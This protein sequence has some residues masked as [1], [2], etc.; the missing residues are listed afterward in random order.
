MKIGID[1][2]V[3]GKKRTGDETYTRELVKNLLKIDNTNQYFLFTNTDSSAEIAEIE[4]ILGL[5]NHKNAC[6][7]PVLPASKV[8]WTFF[9]LPRAL[10]MHPVDILHVQ[11]ITPLWLP[12][13]IKLVTTVHD[14]SFNVFSQYIDKKDLFFLKTLLPWSLKRADAVIGVSQFTKGEILKYYNL[15]EEKV[16]AVLNGGA[17]EGF[18]QPGSSDDARAVAE[19]YQLPSR[20]VLYVG[21]LQPR[22]RIP[23]LV[24]N[25][26]HCISRHK[27]L[28]DVHLV[29]GGN[30]SA[31]NYD[32]EIDIVLE[33][34]REV[35][36]DLFHRVHFPGFFEQEH[37]PEIYRKAE[38]F[39]STSVYE[40]FNLP[41][42]EAMAVGTPVFCEDN[43]C[44]REVTSG[45]ASM[46]AE[47]DSADFVQKLY[48]IL[49]DASLRDSLSEKGRGQAARFSWSVTA[50][51]T[52]AL[53][54][55]L[56]KEN[57]YK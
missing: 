43:A 26:I 45:N 27:E 34:I 55:S 38:V 44:N 2:R 25:F 9:S 11:Y 54:S 14:V 36:P 16:S 52:L 12:R 32:Q 46:Y 31:H 28:S 42:I 7:I 30:R 48:Q 6:V 35:Y 8:M 24:E 47:G 3:I 18:F 20:F 33:K 19:C 53:Y 40:G 57:Q 29:I 23:F 15:P 5:K 4:D 41:L 17:A 49:Q 1:I 21:T 10:K 50:E 51:N 22:K 39:C 56:K 37:L 13:K